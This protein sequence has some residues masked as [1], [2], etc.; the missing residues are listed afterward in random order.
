MSAFFRG[1]K[2]LF[3]VLSVGRLLVYPFAGIGPV[4]A[5][6]LLA[7]LASA[8][9]ERSLR[10]R[11]AS[12]IEAATREPGWLWLWA[13]VIG[14]LVVVLGFATVVRDVARDI[15][16]GDWKPGYYSWSLRCRES[17]TTAVAPKT[18]AD[19]YP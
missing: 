2:S 4:V 5:M 10:T 9:P 12:D 6:V 17:L 3:N 1:F 14:F 19:A 18:P 7:R 11:L 16:V 8:E 13:L 15:D